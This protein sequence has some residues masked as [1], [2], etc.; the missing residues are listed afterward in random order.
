MKNGVFYLDMVRQMVAGSKIVP[1]GTARFQCWID[2]K[3][4]SLPKF[5]FQRPP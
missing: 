4:S 3:S 1:K 5:A 2:C